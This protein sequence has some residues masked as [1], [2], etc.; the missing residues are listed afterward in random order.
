MELH[1]QEGMEIVKAR[2][3]K[4]PKHIK[5]STESNVLEKP[6]AVNTENFPLDG[7]HR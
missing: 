1:A 2:E 3:Q 5:C 4:I 6:E 7:D